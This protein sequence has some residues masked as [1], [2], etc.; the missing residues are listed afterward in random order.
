VENNSTVFTSAYEPGEVVSIPIAHGDGN[1]F[2]DDSALKTL[3]DRE[4]VVFRYSTV[5]GDASEEANPNGSV[6]NIAGI[7][8]EAGNV[9]GMMPHPERAS[10]RV[11]GGDDGQRLFR[12]IIEG[13]V[14]S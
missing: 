7:I 10:E 13:F 14:L 12:S 6:D 9:L 8:N 2:I 5:G 11:L 3:I 1:F 4:G